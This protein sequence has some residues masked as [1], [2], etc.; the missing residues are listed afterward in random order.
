MKKSHIENFRVNKH[1]VRLR[2]CRNQLHS[3][4][5]PLILF[6]MGLIAATGWTGK[7]PAPK[8]NVIRNLQ[9]FPNASGQAAT[10]SVNGDIDESGAFFQSLGANGRSCATCHVASDGFGLSAQTAQ[11]V[12][13]STNGTDPLFSPVD[14]GNCSD[15]KQGDPADHSLLLNHGLIR[16]ALPVPANAQF[17][18]KA[19]SD[20]YGCALVTDPVTQQQTISVYRRPLPA[21][22]LGFLSAVMFDGRETVAPLNNPQ[23]FAANLITDLSQQAIDATTGHAQASAP[24]TSAQVSDIVNFELGLYSAQVSDNQAHNLDA[25][26]AGGG[27]LNL[28]KQNYYPG[29][30]DSLGADPK[31]AAF[32]SLAFNIFDSWLNLKPD[33]GASGTNG[34]DDNGVAEARAKIAAGEQIFNT[35]PLT[36]GNVRGLNDNAALNRPTSFTGTCATCHDSPNVGNHSL[37]LALDIG[38]GH[39]P[40]YETDPTLAAGLTQL[41]FPNV[42]VYEITGCPNPFNAGQIESFFTTDPGRALITGQCGDFNR[43]KG[44]ILRGLAARAPYFH[45]GSAANLTELVNFYN[46]RMQ[47]NLTGE[48]KSD[49]IAFLNSL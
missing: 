17:T 45:N 15:A 28:S 10:Y 11:S 35:F 37:P 41:S 4:S 29:I 33:P 9:P 7:A 40:A 32:N 8:P 21:A 27:P 43:T 13:A 24:P 20:P 25:H 48:Q 18:I 49:L 22:N 5:I 31:G 2:T 38:T 19:V 6:A 44:P 47:M 14:G 46:L 12:F 16:I 34:S 30:N 26:R 36:I 42:P 3:A 23:T 39:S 1:I